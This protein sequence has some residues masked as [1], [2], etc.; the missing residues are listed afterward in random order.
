MSK[1]KEDDN[2]KVFVR[3]RPLKE[4]EIKQGQYKYALSIY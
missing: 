3:C 4:E 1:E 2:V